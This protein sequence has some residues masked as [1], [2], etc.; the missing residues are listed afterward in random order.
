[1]RPLVPPALL[2]VSAATLVGAAAERGAAPPR[3]EHF[4]LLSGAEPIGLVAIRRTEHGE[5]LQLELEVSYSTEDLAVLATERREAGHVELIWREVRPRGGRTLFVQR[6]LVPTE[7]ELR[8][9]GGTACLRQTLRSRAPIEFLP[10][11]LERA[12]AGESGRI[13][14]FDPLSRALESLELVTVPLPDDSGAMAATNTR[15]IELRRMD[16]SPALRLRFAGES[17]EGLAWGQDGQRARRI[18]AEEFRQRR[19]AVQAAFEAANSAIG[20]GE[21][22]A[23]QGFSGG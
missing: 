7:A 6:G 14:H 9:W 11:I 5:A 13:E 19:A 16:G 23:P 21:T 2:L 3:E 15:S 18:T 8:E 10:G 22:S 17:L 1:V 20:P 12:R 4:E